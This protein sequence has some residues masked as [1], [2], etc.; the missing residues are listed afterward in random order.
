MPAPNPVPIAMGQGRPVHDGLLVDRFEGESVSQLTVIK[1]AQH[2]RR[3]QVEK[4]NVKLD[5]E[6]TYGERE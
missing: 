6:T 2:A 3:E 1:D 4:I 5:C